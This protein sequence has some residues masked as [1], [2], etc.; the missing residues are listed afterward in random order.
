MTKSLEDIRK[1]KR[2]EGVNLGKQVEGKNLVSTL[3]C[4]GIKSFAVYLS[5]GSGTLSTGFRPSRNTIY[6]EEDTKRW[7]FIKKYFKKKR[8]KTRF[9]PKKKYLRFKKKKENTLSIKEK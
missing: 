9:R 3:K 5:Q 7:E 8:E 2:G 4:S 6:C 1:S